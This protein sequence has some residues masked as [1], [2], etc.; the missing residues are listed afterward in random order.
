MLNLFHKKTKNSPEKFI[1][2]IISNQNNVGETK[3]FPPATAE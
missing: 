2:P 3:H 1:L